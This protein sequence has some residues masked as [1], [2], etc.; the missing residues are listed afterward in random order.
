MKFF[1]EQDVVFLHLAKYFGKDST[2]ISNISCVVLTFYKALKNE[3][4]ATNDV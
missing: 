1:V 2:N 4:P 3:G